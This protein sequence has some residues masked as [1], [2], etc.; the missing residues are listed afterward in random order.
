MIKAIIRRRKPKKPRAV[1]PRRAW[2]I[3]MR[4]GKLD[5][6]SFKRSD[7]YP[8]TDQGEAI[9]RVLITGIKPK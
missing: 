3:V 7:L 6:I 9:V 5:E 1:R 2:A 8:M 4:G